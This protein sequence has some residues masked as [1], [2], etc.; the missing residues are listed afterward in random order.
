MYK[1]D[2]VCKNSL[3]NAEV[4]I[5]S[6]HTFKSNIVLIMKDIFTLYFSGPLLPH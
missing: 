3:K 5:T 1:V 2:D 4:F 6:Y